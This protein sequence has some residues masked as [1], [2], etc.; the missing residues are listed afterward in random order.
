MKRNRV[1]LAAVGAALVTASACSGAGET[2]TGDDAGGAGAEGVTVA[3]EADPGSLNPITNATQAGE[4]LAA[5]S[6]ESL[7]SFPPGQEETGALADTWEVSTTEAV[8]TLK[9]DITCADGSKLTA[10]DVAATFT[11]A[12]QPDTGSPYR[13]VYFPAEGLTVTPDDQAGTVTF[14]VPTPQSFLNRTLG[15]LPIVCAAGLDDPEALAAKAFGTGP[16]ELTESSPGQSYTF[17]LREDYGW[18]PGGV[19]AESPGLPRTVVATVVTSPSTR[20]NMLQSGE[21]QL[22]SISGIERDRFDEA[23]FS[24]ATTLNLRPGLLF[25]NQA[26]GRPTNDLA[27]RKA[28]ATGLDRDAVGNVASEGYGEQMVNLVPG[29]DTLCPG[30]DSAAALP[31]FDAAKA[32]AMLDEAGWKVGPDGLRVKDGKRLVL[33]VL[34]P[35][36]ESAGLTGAVELMQQKLGEIGVRGEP[37]P[38]A[39][40]T[41]VIFQGGDWDL[42]WAPIYT[43]LPSDWQGILSGEFPPDGGNWTYNTNEEY[44]TLAAEAQGHAGEDSC[45]AWTMAQ[46]SLITDLEVLPVYSSTTTIYGKG[47]SFDLS[48]TI[49]APATLK[50][51]S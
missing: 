22:A 11:Y 3:I 6:Y 48:K 8:F 45:E 25:F 21:V 47:V 10:S 51:D 12:Q 40:Y 37:S 5:F 17:A 31:A 35:S 30:M 16:Y 42:V 36:E 15:S 28:I 4:T 33:K 27:V 29:Y 9:K 39:A 50:L 19:T 38:A 24:T 34:F 20:A 18:G 7:L 49:L 26:P 44:F 41:D 13:G 1:A 2:R 14:T 23:T 43:T 46:D 32:E